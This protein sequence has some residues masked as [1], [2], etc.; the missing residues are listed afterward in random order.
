MSRVSS[1]APGGWLTKVIFSAGTPWISQG[2]LGALSFQ[3]APPGT[4]LATYFA[5][6]VEGSRSTHVTPKLAGLATACRLYSTIIRSSVSR[7]HG[8]T[9]SSVP[10]RESGNLPV[11]RGTRGRPQ[12][13][14][15]QVHGYS[16]PGWRVPQ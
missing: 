11:R 15:L 13:L 14:A 12:A 9:A 1:S 8:H 6:S 16:R 4:W 10:E 2:L 3:L 7:R 5:M